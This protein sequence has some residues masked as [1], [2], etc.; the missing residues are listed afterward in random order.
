VAVKKLNEFMESQGL[1]N[2][3]EA[4]LSLKE[5]VACSQFVRLFKAVQRLK[6]QL[7]QYTDLTEENKETIAQ[8]IPTEQLQGFKVAYLKTAERLKEQQDRGGENISSELEQLDFE[9]VLFNSVI[10][11]YDYIMH[12]IARYSAEKPSKQTMSREQLVGLIDADAKFMEEREDIVAYIDTLKVGE[13]LSEEE[14]RQGYEK[15]KAEKNARELAEIAAKHSLETDA[16]QDFVDEIMRRMIFDGDQLSDLF[17]PLEL[18]WKVRAQKESALMG[19]LIPQLH[20]LAQGREI[21]GLSV[22]EE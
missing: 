14:I 2:K 6:T 20:K 21:S 4:V 3:P 15:F 7:D 12:L 10:I 13:G 19:D 5:D 22:Y 16:L 9:F 17:A 18:S 11:D 8:I 1:E